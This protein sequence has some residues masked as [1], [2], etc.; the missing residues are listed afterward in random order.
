MSLIGRACSGLVGRGGRACCI[1]AIFLV[2]FLVSV[3]PSTK[4]LAT[5]GMSFEVTDEEVLS[6]KG[7]IALVTAEDACLVVVE[8]MTKE[9]V[10]S[11]I[12]LCTAGLIACVPHLGRWGGGF[13]A[14]HVES[15]NVVRTFK[16]LC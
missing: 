4:R 15:S 12:T 1:V 10:G 13:F 3:G 9:M 16:R 14:R 11:R 2:A 6:D 5:K 7:T 8:L